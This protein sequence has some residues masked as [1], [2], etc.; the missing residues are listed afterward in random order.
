MCLDFLK[1]SSLFYGTS[2]TL[3]VK[4]GTYLPLYFAIIV[5]VGPCLTYVYLSPNDI[6]EFVVKTQNEHHPD[7]E[8]L[9]RYTLR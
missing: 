8:A 7:D 4:L 5:D 9:G 1:L 2:I 6:I 3:V